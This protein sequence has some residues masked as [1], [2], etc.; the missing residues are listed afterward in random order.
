MT[1]GFYLVNG[2]A[3][4]DR[5]KSGMAYYNNLDQ[6]TVGAQPDQYVDVGNAGHYIVWEN[7]TIQG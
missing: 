7:E 1:N 6:A 4:G 3:D 2:L 5:H